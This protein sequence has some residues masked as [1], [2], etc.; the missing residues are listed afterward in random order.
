MERKLKFRMWNFVKHNP[1][2]SKMFYDVDEVTACLRQQLL[3]DSGKTAAG[4]SHT[5]DG[6]YFMQSTELQDKNGKEIYE[7]DIL[8]CGYG[9]GKVIYNAGCFMVCWIED[10]EAYMEFVFSRKG[11][12]RRKD[13]E[14]FEVIGNIHENPEI[15]KSFERGE[16]KI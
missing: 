8:Q 16:E 15:I 10:K 5:E 14:E 2:L 4:Y 9:V 6:N 13:D 3:F 7:G 1:T 12:Y 11:M